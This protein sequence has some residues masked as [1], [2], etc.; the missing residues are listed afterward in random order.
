MLNPV[1]WTSFREKNHQPSKEGM[2][3]LYGTHMLSEEVE[4]WWDN[5]RQRFEAN[6]I[7]LT[8]A[9]FRDAFLEKYFPAD[10]RSKKEI[11][12]L[13]F[14]QGNMILAD[15]AAKFEELSRFFPH[16]NMCRI[17]D[18]DSRAR[19][20]HYKSVSEKKNG[21]QSRGKPYVTPV[22]KEDHKT[23]QNTTS[24]G[25]DHTPIKSFKCEKLG[26]RALECTAMKC[27]KCGKQGHRANEC[28]GAVVT[29]LN[30]GEQGHIRTQC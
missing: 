8:W 24:G 30:Y 18:E 4:Y 15:Y 22:A 3:V 21:N 23:H 1:G 7:A 17:Y 29:C 6:G 27:Y 11:E 13:K 25:G 16:Y 28:K 9:I 19:F 14:K 5:D 2:K 10:V 20:A 26:H 12:F